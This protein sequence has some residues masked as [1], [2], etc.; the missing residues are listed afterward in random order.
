MERRDSKRK[1]VSISAELISDNARYAVFIENMSK[2][3]IYIV[4]KPEKTKID[5]TTG[6]KYDVKFQAASGTLL[7]LKCRV[8]WTYKTPPHGLTYSVGM[9]IIDPPALYKEF[10]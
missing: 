6:K 8:K 2:D 10:F 4:T 5:F 9:E 7:N 1:I 3:G